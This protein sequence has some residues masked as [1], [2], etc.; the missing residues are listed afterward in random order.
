MAD[1]DPSFPQLFT[2]KIIA[3]TLSKFKGIKEFQQHP[4]YLNAKSKAEQFFMDL[5]S[6]NINFQFIDDFLRKN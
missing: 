5:S 1:Y 6:E 4:F 3:E 2:D